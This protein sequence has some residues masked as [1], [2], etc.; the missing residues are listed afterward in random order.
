MRLEDT[1]AQRFADKVLYLAVG[2]NLASVGHSLWHGAYAIAG[3]SAVVVPVLLTGHIA[4]LKMTAILEMKHAKA[5]AE[6]QKVEVELQM[7]MRMRDELDQAINRGY[8]SFSL[9]RYAGKP[10]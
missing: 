3:L 9:D 5:Q 1:R 7:A 4:R 8:F 2:L 6:L 10:Q